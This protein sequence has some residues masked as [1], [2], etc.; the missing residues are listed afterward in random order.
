M[1]DTGAGMG[2]NIVAL[3]R[4]PFKLLFFFTSRSRHARFAC[5]WSSDVCSSDLLR[6]VAGIIGLNVAFV[7]LIWLLPLFGLERRRLDDFEVVDTPLARTAVP[8]QQATPWRIGPRLLLLVVLTGALALADGQLGS[9]AKG[10]EESGR[11]AVA[12]FVD[13]PTAGAGWSVQRVEEIG[14]ASPYY[15]RHSSWVRY[16][17]RPIGQ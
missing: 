6:P 14:W 13:R 15:G 4:A 5:D 11:P 9:A 16:R 1:I 2:R 8:A 10:L 17:L 12:A 3:T 7:L